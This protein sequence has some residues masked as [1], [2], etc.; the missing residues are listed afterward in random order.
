MFYPYILHL[1]MAY[2]LFRTKMK[3]RKLLIIMLFHNQNHIILKKREMIKIILFQTFFALKNNPYLYSNI[4]V[5]HRKIRQLR[6]LRHPLSMNMRLFFLDFQ[7]M[8]MRFLRN[9]NQS[10]AH[11]YSKL[12]PTCLMGPQGGASRQ[13]VIEATIGPQPSLAEF[14]Q[15]LQGQYPIQEVNGEFEA[16]QVHSLFHSAIQSR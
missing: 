14:I 6:P 15:A 12:F 13:I 10:L 5:S 16:I 4:T 3:Q 2:L 8:T 9:L 11:Y 7:N 1:C